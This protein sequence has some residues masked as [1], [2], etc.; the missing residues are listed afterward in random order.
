[1][2]AL[3]QA[4]KILLTAAVLASLLGAC[5]KTEP[6]ADTTTMP[7]TSATVPSSTS[8]ATGTTGDTGTGATGTTTDPTM[9]PPPAETTTDPAVVPPPVGTGA[10]GTGT[11]GTT[12]PPTTGG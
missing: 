11:T 10:T 4:P 7:D 3:T 2:K 1:M 5:R 12:T 9:T 8:G 6:V